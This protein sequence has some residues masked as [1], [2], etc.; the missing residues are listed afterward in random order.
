MATYARGISAAKGHTLAFLEG[1]D[2]WDSNYLSEKVRVLDRFSD[3][4]VVFSACRFLLD[5]YFGIDML[6]RQKVLQLFLPKER[7]FNNF[8]Y[9]L[10]KNNVATFSAFAARA[11]LVRSVPRLRTL[12]SVS[13]TGG[14]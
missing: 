5:G 8:E 14:C 6:A 1:D 7:P 10:R 11:D 9:L 12:T 4:G 2:L 13:T 3:V